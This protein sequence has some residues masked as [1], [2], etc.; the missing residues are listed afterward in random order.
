MSG[1]KVAHVPLALLGKIEAVM[2]PPMIKDEM[3]SLNGW[4]YVDIEGRDIGGYVNEAKETVKKN[5]KL[6]QGYYL[7]WTGQY[8]FLERIQALM[9]W[10]VPL[11][12]LL[13]AIVL[14]FNFK[15]IAQPS[16]SCFQ[17]LLLQSA[18]SG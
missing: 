3:A 10:V 15:G 9:Q 12:I 18:Q 17:F 5:L 13:I 2:G 1:G 8:E 6:P 16:S 7:K 14:Y 4:V 11:T